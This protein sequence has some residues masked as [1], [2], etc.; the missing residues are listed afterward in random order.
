MGLTEIGWGTWRIVDA[1]M[2]KRP[3][4]GRAARGSLTWR[5]GSARPSAGR[6]ASPSLREARQAAYGHAPPPPRAGREPSL[7]E[8]EREGHDRTAN[9]SRND[10]TS[11]GAGCVLSATL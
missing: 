2:K 9:E 4:A 7:Q 11:D 8:R 6:L 10:D 3:L 1:N 5:I